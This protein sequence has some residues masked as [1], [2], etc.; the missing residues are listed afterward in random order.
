VPW[1]VIVKIV[2]ASGDPFGGGSDPASANYW[3][4]EALIYRSG[5]LEDLPGIRAPRCLGIDRTRVVEA[6]IWL[7]DI[8][9]GCGPPWSAARYRLAARR[10]GEFN[11]AYLAGRPLPPPGHLSRD[12][13]R[14]FV[15][16]FGPAFARLPSVRDEPFVRRCWPGGL[17][18]R[19]LRL[20][21]DRETFLRALDRMPQTFCHLDAFP[22]N[23]LFD[24]TGRE[25]V[26]LDWSY[27]GIAPVGAEL[28]P[29]VAGSVSFF[30]AEPERMRSIDEVVFAGYLRG[31][32]AAGWDADPRLVR[33]GYTAAASLRYGLFP[34]GVFMLDEDLRAHFE[35]VFAHPVIEILDRWAEVAGFLL[36]QADEARR[37]LRSGNVLEGGE[38]TAVSRRRYPVGSTRAIRRHTHVG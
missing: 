35:R 21:E 2:H 23:L 37:A 33:L 1:S 16:D 6:R 36:D 10:L 8:P 28:A 29:M 20:W 3:E 14:A 30:D 24:G 34:L 11:G 13:L 32:R 9:K 4:R 7:E 38:R 5:L 17:L 15:G 12:W 25:V 26:A 31:L 18:D 27:A 19:V 22:R